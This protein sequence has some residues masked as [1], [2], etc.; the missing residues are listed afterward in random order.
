VVG[1]DDPAVWWP[2]DMGA[3][4]LYDLGLT[5]AVGG[6]RS[7]VAHSRF[8]VRDVKATLNAGGRQYGVLTM[9]GWECCDKWEG[10]VNGGE[11][12]DAWT[13]ADY[14]IAK[15]STTGEAERLRDHPGVISFHIGSDFAP[16]RPSRRATWTRSRRP[17]GPPR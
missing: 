4:P 14:P 17:T 9:P 8:G 7:D 12:G 10:Q 15:A 16:T 3:Q 2:H 5:A 6:A 1:V 11:V 13:P